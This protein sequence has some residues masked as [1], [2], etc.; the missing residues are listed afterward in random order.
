[1]GDWD[2]DML[3]FHVCYICFMEQMLDHDGFSELEIV[4]LTYVFA[5]FGATREETIGNSTRSQELMATGPGKA[6]L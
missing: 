5:K 2:W 6:V 1:M 4:D 3:I